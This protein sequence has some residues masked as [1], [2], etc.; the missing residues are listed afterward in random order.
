MT[1]EFLLHFIDLE[2]GVQLMASLAFA[3][4]FLRKNDSVDRCR[5]DNVL[6]G[7]SAALL[8]WVFICGIIEMA[9][10]YPDIVNQQPI[11]RMLVQTDTLC[12]P[13]GCLMLTSLTRR[14]PITLEASLRHVLPFIGLIIVGQLWLDPVFAYLSATLICIY[15]SAMTYLLLLAASRYNHYI[16]DQYSDFY[17]LSTRW[18]GVVIVGMILISIM[19]F[20]YIYVR[21]TWV[22]AVYTGLK[23]ILWGVLTFNLHRVLAVRETSRY[24]LDVLD[25]QMDDDYLPVKRAEE[26]AEPVMSVYHAEEDADGSAAAETPAYDP[27]AEFEHRL[28]VICETPRL[29]TTEDITRDELARAMMMN[30]TYLT[31]MLKQ[32]KG[33]SFYEYINGLR[34]QY[35]AELLRDPHFPLDAIPLEV[36]YKHR[37]TYYRVFSDCYGCTPT[38]Y[39][40]RLCS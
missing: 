18:I 6:R 26:E 37:S 38:E 14:K 27:N 20:V 16:R 30:H 15:L 19:W 7:L 29:Y 32:I 34:M 23:C 1:N 3:V 28:E 40:T 25:L 8:G 22:E 12:F 24:N 17:G 36:G 13:L 2:R 10:W 39:R 5:R 11:S 21:E 4:S 35:A 31:K 33:K 9:T